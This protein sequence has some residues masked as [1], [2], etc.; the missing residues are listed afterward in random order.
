[1]PIWLR[2]FY[3]K[4]IE[5]VVQRQK[6]QQSKALKKNQKTPMNIDK[7]SFVSKR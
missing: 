2:K 4:K 6:E 3:Y 7:P 1:M 5:E